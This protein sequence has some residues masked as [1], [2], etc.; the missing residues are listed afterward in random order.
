MDG[1]VRWGSVFLGGLG[2]GLVIDLLLLGS[3]WRISRFFLALPHDFATELSITV[4]VL[5]FLLTILTTWLYAVVRERYK[6]GIVT[7][8]LVGAGL[9]LFMTSVNYL[10][11]HLILGQAL[12][13]VWLLNAGLAFLILLISTMLGAW[14]YERTSAR[15]S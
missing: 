15:P 2:A 1:R 7:A 5:A 12:T 3:G 8:A 6:P 10:G 9:G 4:A 11:S 13:R 14:I